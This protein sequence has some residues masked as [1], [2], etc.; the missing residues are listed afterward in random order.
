MFPLRS[1]FPLSW[2]LLAIVLTLSLGGPLNAQL[3]QIQGNNRVISNGD[4]TPSSADHTDFGQVL[5]GSGP[6]DRQFLIRNLG[7]TPLQILF[8]QRTGPHPA[9]FTV[10]DPP[11]LLIP[12]NES[13]AMTIRF[14]PPAAGGLRT[15]T[16]RIVSTSSVN[17]DFQ[18]DVAGELVLPAPNIVISGNEVEIPDGASLPAVD[19]NT[20]FGT[21]GLDDAPL[22]RTFTI[23][24]TGEK[25]LRVISVDVVGINSD[26]FSIS[27][28]PDTFIAPDNQSTF[29]L[30]FNP[31]REGTH[32]VT[33]QVN[34]ND[35]TPT[36]RTYSF[37]LRGTG[38]SFLPRLILSGNGIDIAPGDETPDPEDHTRFPGTDLLSASTRTFTVHNSGNGPLLIDT[39]ELIGPHAVEFTVAQT[40][41]TPLDPEG[42][43]TLQITFRPTTQGSR[44]ASLRITSNDPA[45][46]LYEVA[47]EGIGGRFKLLGIERDD[48]DT[49]INFNANSSPGIYIYRILHS[50]DMENWE[51]VGSIFSS[52]RETLQFRHRNS[53]ATP[54]GFWHVEELPFE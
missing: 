7:P 30:T 6:V 22:T 2:S 47:L 10:I 17:N 43:S 33:V 14:L 51:A 26:Q 40:P 44:F 49:L 5:T 27:R 18:F 8:F 19:N 34:S 37:T 3:I 54:R 42:V 24:N 11:D 32:R 16:I 31:T 41:A 20:D 15:A 4:T 9:N 29:D 38:R 12:G 23:R 46:P 48:D 45:Q 52:G 21:L 25:N 28:H 35:P 53:R 1:T 39:V 13:S 50:I 36:E